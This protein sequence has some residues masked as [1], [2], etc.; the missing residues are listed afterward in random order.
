MVPLTFGRRVL[1]QG[2]PN[3]LKLS[4]ERSGAERVRCSAVF[5]RWASLRLIGL[6]EK[7]V[8]DTR[9]GNVVKS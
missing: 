8:S 4:G 1:L 7:R 6:F 2:T 5:G 9:G 3:V